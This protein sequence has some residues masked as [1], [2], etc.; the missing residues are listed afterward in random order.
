MVGR[1]HQTLGEEPCAVVTVKPGATATEA[2]LKAFVAE[3][4]ASFKVPV[5]IIV[6]AEPL[7]RNANGKIL[8]GELKGLFA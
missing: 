2:E 4:I 7:P 5:A 3:R 1:A 6:R 8:K